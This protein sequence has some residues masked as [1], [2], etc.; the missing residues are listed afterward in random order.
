MQS[1]VL[2][3]LPHFLN[4]GPV[5]TRIPDEQDCPSGRIRHRSRMAMSLPSLYQVLQ[6]RVVAGN[7]SVRSES[8]GAKTRS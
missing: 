5:A 4:V 6:I 7:D 8:W 2:V 1:S 3:T